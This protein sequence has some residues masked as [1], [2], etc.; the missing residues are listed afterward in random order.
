MLTHCPICTY[1][2]SGLPQSHTCP[3]CGFEYDRRTVVIWQGNRFAW[4][5]LFFFGLGGLGNLPIGF[6]VGGRAWWY[7]VLSLCMLHAAW[8]GAR[9]LFLRRKNRVVV[10]P[11]GVTTV[12]AGGAIRRYPWS[13]FAT[14]VYQVA[15]GGVVLVSDTGRAVGVIGYD[16]LGSTQRVRQAIEVIN[17]FR[18]SSTKWGA[19]R[20]RRQPDAKPARSVP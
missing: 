1:D 11:Q 15:G 3:E 5:A 20:L 16:F 6:V 13:A 19:V 7:T 17:G 14:A 9:S 10:G 8:R 18:N 2:L 12:D 4:F